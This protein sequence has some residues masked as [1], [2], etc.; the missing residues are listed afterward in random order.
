MPDADASAWESYR[1]MRGIDD[2]T[3]YSAAAPHASRPHE[4]F[5]ED[6]RALFGGP[7]A[8]YSGSIENATIEPPQ[9]VPG[10]RTFMLAL[11]DTWMRA[12]LTG[13][14]NPSRG[15][16]TFARAVATSVPLELFD[17]AGRR[18]ATVPALAVAGG[19]EWRWDGRD[20]RGARPSPGALFARLRGT[21]GAPL[22]VTLLP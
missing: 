13:A 6:F 2:P 20:S 9:Q 5:A 11:A 15:S 8:N 7:S 3:V 17:L 4:I 14:P 22:R 21:R 1:R 18:I 10:L 19:T 16:V 12:G